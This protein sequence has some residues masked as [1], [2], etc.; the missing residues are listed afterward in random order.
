MRDYGPLVQKDFV[1]NINDL[2]VYV[3]ESLHFTHDLSQE[4]SEDSYLYFHFIQSITYF[5]NIHHCPL[6]CA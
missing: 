4:K 6:L 2:A 1:T 5:S 3:K